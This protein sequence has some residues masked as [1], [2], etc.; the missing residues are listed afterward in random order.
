M[1]P[2]IHI[3]GAGP[4]GLA[5]ALTI[6][7]A[8]GR[9]IVHERKA[10]VGSRFRG[11]FQGLENWTTPEDVLE[12]LS[13]AGIQ[14]RFAPAPFREVVLFTPDGREHRCRSEAPLFYLVRRGPQPGTLDHSL[15][16]QALEAGVEIRFRDPIRRLPEGGI[17]AEG[18]RRADAIAVGYTF[19]TYMT[20]G[21]YAALSDAIAPKGYAYLLI[22]RGRGTVAS[23]M[24]SGFHDE[25]IH[26]ASTLEWF[27]ERAGL[28]M[29]DP[30]PFG[31]LG[32]FSAPR[33]NA[34]DRLLHVGES[35]G[36]QDPLWGFGMRV[37]MLS[38]HLAARAF[39]EGRPDRF[40]ALWKERLGGFRKSG[41][42]NR[43]AFSRLGDRGYLLLGRRASG[44]KD[45]R[46]WLRRHYAPSLAKS[47]LFPLVRRAV[48][49]PVESGACPIE[50][51]DCT[52]CRCRRSGHGFEG[53]RGPA[54][55]D[56]SGAFGTG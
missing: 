39:L 51:C 44:A 53:R 16:V 9:A 20:D 34:N 29:V 15:R 19:D 30:V 23:C 32:A 41:F 5:A 13:D 35:G 2:A 54:S 33:A 14:P 55:T 38:G 10:T 11:D 1:T 36:F 46:D 22:H 48:L 12:E 25:K 37:A 4:A 26:L 45:L 18:P 56:A 43:F 49:K 8:G 21:A 50:G 17:V 40:E 52:W 27:R 3:S 7:R 24:F 31:G 28:R 42:V 6:A 47:F